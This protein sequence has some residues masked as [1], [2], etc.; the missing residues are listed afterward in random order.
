[1]AGY[2]AVDSRPQIPGLVQ[3]GRQVSPAPRSALEIQK[4][5]LCRVLGV[6]N[7]NKGTV[8]ALR[9]LHQIGYLWRPGTLGSED[10]GSDR[11]IQSPYCL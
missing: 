10:S 1:M 3:V 2:E 8:L 9:W 6:V 7:S 5:Y 4:W 11:L